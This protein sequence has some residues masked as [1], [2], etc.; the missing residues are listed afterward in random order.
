MQKAKI[1][2]ILSKTEGL[3]NDTAELY[4][5]LM[6]G[7]NKEAIKVITKMQDTLKGLKGGIVIKEE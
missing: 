4:E 6:D 2:F 3:H 1:N 7:E 5:A